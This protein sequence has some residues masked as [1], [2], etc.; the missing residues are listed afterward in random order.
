M[1]V[2]HCMNSGFGAVALFSV[3]FR[4]RYDFHVTFTC[5][6]FALPIFGRQR[7]RHPSTYTTQRVVPLAK[8]ATSPFVLLIYYMHDNVSYGPALT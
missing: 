7:P 1:V 6:L 2:C 5:C 8:L 4:T 3:H